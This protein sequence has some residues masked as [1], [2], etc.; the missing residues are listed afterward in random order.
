MEILDN[1]VNR[2]HENDDQGTPEQ[3]ADN[4]RRIKINTLFVER[5]QLANRLAE[6]ESSEVSERIKEIDEEIA[7]LESQQK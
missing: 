7:E 3:I 1:E 5:G 2:D 4:E 6:G